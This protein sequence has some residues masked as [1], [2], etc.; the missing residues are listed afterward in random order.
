MGIE[1]LINEGIISQFYSIPTGHCT[2]RW[3]EGRVPTSQG[4][5]SETGL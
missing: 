5:G 3:V 1:W 4:L 2:I